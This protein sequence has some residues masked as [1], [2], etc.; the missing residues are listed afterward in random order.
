[1]NREPGRLEDD[2]GVG[3]RES[4]GKGDLALKPEHLGE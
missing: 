2:L 1:M 4:E 3:M